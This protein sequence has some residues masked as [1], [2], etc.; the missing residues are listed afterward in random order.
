MIGNSSLRKR[1]SRLAAVVVVAV[2]A[3]LSGQI[4]TGAAQ[5]PGSR[6]LFDNVV[7]VLQERYYDR[8]FRKNVLPGLAAQ[9]REKAARATTLQAQRQ[10]IHE[11]LSRIP[12]SHLGLL[13]KEAH[14]NIFNDLGNRTRPTFGFQ[15]VEVKGKQYT[16]GILEG[17]PAEKA[18]LLAWDCIVTVDGLPPERSPR[19]D[20]R[21]DDAYLADDR[22]PPVRA[23]LGAEGDRIAI[24][25]ERRRGEF[26]QLVVTAE[27]YSV[28]EA[29]RKSARVYRTGDRCF[30]YIH[31][32]Y[33]H[34]NGVPELLREKLEGDF[35][36]CHGLVLDLRGRG[37]NG[38]VVPTLIELL[39]SWDKPIV[40][41]VDRQSRSAKDV[42]AYELRRTRLAK[43][44]GEKTAGAV[45]P[46]SFADVGYDTILMFPSFKMPRY[47]DL[48]ELKPVEPDVFV[49]RAGPYSAGH[50]PIL[51]AGLAEIEKVVEKARSQY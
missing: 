14:R 16:F 3:A 13:S 5:K 4:S 49:E 22:D 15:L 27:Q 46:G 26:K 40:A 24:K 1:C 39:K 21:T 48:L 25:I 38:V 51:K 23:L 29:A 30:G 44:V 28:F 20:W 33:I 32:S 8:D 36:G 7:A 35:S 12:A 18:G 6:S 43:L 11:F 47:T 17:G 45:I 42:L 34:I 41:L 19:L 37:G 50:D 10:I 2:A 31:F 9:F